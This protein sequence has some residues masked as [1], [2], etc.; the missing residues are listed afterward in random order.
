M[1]KR[2]CWSNTRTDQTR[3][4]LIEVPNTAHQVGCN[5]ENEIMRFLGLFFTL[6]MPM[7]V[8]VH[9]LSHSLAS[10]NDIEWALM[11]HG[12]AAQFCN[13]VGERWQRKK[14]VV[15]LHPLSPWDNIKRNHMTGPV[16]QVWT[17]IPQ[18]LLLLQLCRISAPVEGAK[19][20]L[21]FWMD[22]LIE[23][24]RQSSHWG[25]IKACLVQ[26]RRRLFRRGHHPLHQV[27][28]VAPDRRPTDR[29]SHLH[30]FSP[31]P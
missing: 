23:T 4:D 31:Q 13:G 9:S 18:W 14:H 30:R 1:K 7:W 5:Q 21:L 20:W 19:G 8:K 22:R 27:Q 29:P 25:N 12:I 24:Q 28:V 11:G 16:W 10:G 3:F 17:E 2:V 15:S 26:R 6:P